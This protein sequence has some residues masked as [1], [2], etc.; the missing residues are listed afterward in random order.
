MPSSAICLKRS[1]AQ[2]ILSR[3]L[4]E[5]FFFAALCAINA[6]GF[7]ELCLLPFLLLL[8]RVL[9]MQKRMF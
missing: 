6:F 9:G 1:K 8:M 7:Y 3:K 2:S 5:R 4:S